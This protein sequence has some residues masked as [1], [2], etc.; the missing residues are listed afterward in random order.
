MARA[1]VVSHL[2][3]C[4]DAYGRR[5][6]LVRLGS[7]AARV[8]RAAAFFSHRSCGVR[9]GSGDFRIQSA[10]EIEPAAEA[11]PDRAALLVEGAAA[12]QVFVSIGPHD[13]RVFVALVVSYFYPSLE[14]LLF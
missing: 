12:G 3:D 2:D 7:D 9:R 14:G 5:V 11:L 4:C 13:D 6:D 1:A 10:E 8:W